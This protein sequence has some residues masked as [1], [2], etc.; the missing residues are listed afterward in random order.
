MAKNRR[1]KA[2]CEHD[3]ALIA[4][5]VLIEH[6]PYAAIAAELGISENMVKYD[7]GVLK[8]RW[9]ASALADIAT[10][11]GAE[12][13]RTHALE[14]EYWEAWE[15]SKGEREKTK[16]TSIEVKRGEGTGRIPVRSELT[17][18]DHIGDAT[19][20]QGVERQIDR[21]AR[22]LGLNAPQKVA[23]TD[24][25]GEH[26]A[27][28]PTEALIDALLRIKRTGIDG[29]GHSGELDGDGDPPGAGDTPA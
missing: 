18:E 3:R 11:K 27:A 17:V 10:L 23:A 14:A 7:M 15:R 2:Q 1:T 24:P 29:N 8:K 13:D 22:I 9:R 25:T 19:Y 4:R 16:L 28:N 20:L 26:E 5:M 12:V 21:R 6:K